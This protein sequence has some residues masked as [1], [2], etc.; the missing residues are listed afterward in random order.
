MALGRALK[1]KA[2]FRASVSKSRDTLLSETPA[3]KSKPTKQY[4]DTKKEVGSDPHFVQYKPNTGSG[5]VK[6]I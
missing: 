4:Q 5:K 6:L 1:M 3:A 2:G